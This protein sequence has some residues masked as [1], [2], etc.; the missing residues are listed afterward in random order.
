MVLFY[1]K[2]I[3]VASAKIGEDLSFVNKNLWKKN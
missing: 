3:G 2:I 1:Q